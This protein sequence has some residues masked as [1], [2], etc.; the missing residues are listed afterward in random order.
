MDL[1]LLRHTRVAAAPGTCYGQLDL[2]LLLPADPPF[3][4]VAR[5]LDAL[6]TELGPVQ[7]IVSSPLQRAALLAADLAARQ[8][9]GWTTDPRWME[10][11]FGDWE[12]RRWSDIPREQSDP[13]AADYHHRAPPG[14]ETHAQLQA[15]VFAAAH[16]GLDEAGSAATPTASTAASPAAARRGPVLVVCHA[17]P[18]RCLMALAQGLPASQLPSASLAFGGLMWLRREPSGPSSVAPRWVLKRG[19]W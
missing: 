7:R 4:D 8:G 13:W 6:C 14:G 1:I 5:R 16:D 18:M 19:P 15:R 11:N 2:P 9:L 12:G 10:L 17:G 3:D